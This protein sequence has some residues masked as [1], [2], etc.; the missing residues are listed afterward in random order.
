MKRQVGRE[1]ATLAVGGVAAVT[2]TI[3]AMFTAVPQSFRSAID[4][5]TW[6]V[7][8]TS[9]VPLTIILVVN[10]ISLL[11]KTSS[12]RESE[13]ESLLARIPR[14]TPISQFEDSS[15]AMEY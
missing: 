12:D 2:S 7:V 3:L 8:L 11:L 14:T 13:L 6:T 9:T 4:P 10:Q 15:A 1:W 5:I